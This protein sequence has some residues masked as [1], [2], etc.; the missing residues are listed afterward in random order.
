[1]AQRTFTVTTDGVDWPAGK[2]AGWIHT[3]LQAASNA[4]NPSL[5]LDV[6]S[7]AEAVEKKTEA[8]ADKK[9]VSGKGKS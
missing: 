8:P 1:M 3:Q 6:V 5:D 2:L 7:V 9:G 4:A